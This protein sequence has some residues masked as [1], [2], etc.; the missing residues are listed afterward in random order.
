MSAIAK[1]APSQYREKAKSENTLRAYAGAMGRFDGWAQAR[2]LSSLP[3]E[4]EDVATYL[5]ILAN[6]GA[7]VATVRLARAAIA[8]T[9]TQGGFGDPT[10]DAV[11]VD[12]LKGIARER[13]TA[14]QQ[15]A[16][17]TEAHAIAICEAA[18]EQ[19]W[20]K[21]RL[22]CALVTVMRDGLLRRSEAAALTWRDVVPATDG[23]GRV[24]IRRSK[25]DQEGEGA[26]VYM[27]QST[28]QHLREWKRDP[29]RRLRR[30]LVFGISPQTI[31]RRIAR[32]ALAAGLEGAYS[33]HS[34]RIGMAQDLAEAGVEMPRA[35][36][37]WPMVVARDAGAV[38][39][40]HRSG[41]GRSR[42]G[43]RR[44]ERTP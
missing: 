19:Q 6:E 7:S 14:P 13:G 28:A 26:I 24:A 32:A 36:A 23:S 27:R 16:P 37:G 43:V 38:Y 34:P 40:T 1:L 33:G 29:A 4:A 10:R 44:Q 25:T 17:L 20:R 8:H 9:H 11:V 18:A 2:Y 22:D 3:A 21:W 39:C 5:S 15:A 31:C 41:P 42:P 12:T 30:T 35:H